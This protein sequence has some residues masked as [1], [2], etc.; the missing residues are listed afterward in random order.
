MLADGGPTDAY[1]VPR[2]LIERIGHG[3]A[4]A[5]L[6]RPKVVAGRVLVDAGAGGEAVPHLALEGQAGGVVGRRALVDGTTLAPGT[7]VPDRAIV[8]HGTQV[9][10][11]E[12]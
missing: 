1:P 6:Q 8:V 2:E 12:W 9:G 3:H 5:A 7:V 10:T 4:A 11:V